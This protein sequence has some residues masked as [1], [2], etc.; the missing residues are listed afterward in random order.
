[1]YL[2][3]LWYVCM[4]VCSPMSPRDALVVASAAQP[5]VPDPAHVE[6][7]PVGPAN[8]LDPAEEEFWVGVV[9]RYL[10]PLEVDLEHQTLVRAQLLELRNKATLSFFMMN[11]IFVVVIFTLQVCATFF[12][13]CGWCS[14]YHIRLPCR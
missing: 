11:A 14:G 4:Y 3:Q 2:L 1:M 5:S 6:D 12:R 8:R 13:Y 10:V 9:K 7:T